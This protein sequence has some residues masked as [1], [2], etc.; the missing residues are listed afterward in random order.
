[1]KSTYYPPQS[2]V[3]LISTLYEVALGTGN[4]GTVGEE[5]QLSKKSY[6]NDDESFKTSHSLWDDNEDDQ[7]DNY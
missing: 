2:E 1:M 5:H 4:S 6:I 7:K 3:V